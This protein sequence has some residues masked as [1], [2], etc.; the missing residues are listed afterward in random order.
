MKMWSLWSSSQREGCLG[1]CV[2]MLQKL[3]CEDVVI[4]VSLTERGLSWAVCTVM[5]QKLLCE[6]VVIVVSFTERGLSWEICIDKLPK[7]RKVK[8]S[9]SHRAGW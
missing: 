5:L 6:D 4:V 1:Q 9:A 8:C 3:L 2:V 7:Y